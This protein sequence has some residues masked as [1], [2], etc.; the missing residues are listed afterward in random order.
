MATIDS[1]VTK[2][3]GEKAFCWS[4]VERTVE[5]LLRQ[6][7]KEVTVSQLTDLAGNP[8]IIDWWASG[9]AWRVWYKA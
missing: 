6:L 7:D 1:A 3:S 5:R 2:L 4:V 8:M 9:E